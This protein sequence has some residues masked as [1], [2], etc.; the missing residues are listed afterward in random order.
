M[1]PPHTRWNRRAFAIRRVCF[2]TYH[3]ISQHFARVSFAISF[4]PSIASALALSVWVCLVCEYNVWGGFLT[5]VYPILHHHAFMH[6]YYTLYE[7]DDHSVMMVWCSHICMCSSSRVSV[8]VS[9]RTSRGRP[10]CV[11][12]ISPHILKAHINVYYTH[13]Y[14]RVTCIWKW[15]LLHVAISLQIIVTYG[16]RLYVK[17]L[18]V[19]I[20]VCCFYCGCCCYC[21]FFVC[22]F[23]FCLPFNRKCWMWIGVNEHFMV[24]S[25]SK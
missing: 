24:K 18:F 14:T 12:K 6:Y 7:N 3:R 15:I 17:L 19:T 8:D 21:Y 10:C 1:C 22:L 13:I 4:P 25:N 20:A 5:Y 23:L 16:K 11:C 2:I 9:P